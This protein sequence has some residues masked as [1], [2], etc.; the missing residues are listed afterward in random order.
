MMCYLYIIQ[1][2]DKKNIP[3]KAWQKKCSKDTLTWKISKISVKR[4]GGKGSFA[5][6]YSIMGRGIG[7]RL[8]TPAQ[9]T[10]KIYKKQLI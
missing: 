10:F 2:I 3:Q 7:G 4:R 1:Q 5:G 6:D 9:D 8:I